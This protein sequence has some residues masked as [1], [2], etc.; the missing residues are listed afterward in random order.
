MHF[1]TSFLWFGVSKRGVA[2]LRGLWRCTKGVASLMGCGVITVNVF[3]KGTLAVFL[4]YRRPPSH[5]TLL[6]R[7]HTKRFCT[8]ILPKSFL[9]LTFSLENTLVARQSFC[10]RL[11]RDTFLPKGISEKGKELCREGFLFLPCNN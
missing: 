10:R 6:M 9:C 3:Q 11:L 1:L 8:N 4:G 7:S 2:L 5:N